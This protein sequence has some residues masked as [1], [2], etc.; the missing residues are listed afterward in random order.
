MCQLGALEGID[1]V[2]IGV[3]EAHTA[4]LHNHGSILRDA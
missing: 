1:G 4:I 2:P 3:E